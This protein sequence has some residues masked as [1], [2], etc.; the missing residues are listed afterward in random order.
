M[1]RR[2]G[3]AI[4]RWNPA[5]GGVWFVYVGGF[6][7][8]RVKRNPMTDLWSGF[9]P[10]SVP[11]IA[12]TRSRAIAVRRVVREWLDYPQTR[13][14]AG[15]DEPP[16]VW[17]AFLRL[18]RRVRGGA[19]PDPW[20]KALRQ[21]WALAGPPGRADAFGYDEDEEEDG[22]ESDGHAAAERKSR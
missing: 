8:G 9:S 2:T 20:R 16:E 4:L 14:E 21:A 13:R 3:A 22:P 7:V 1:K 12:P 19:W 17:R 11:F 15:G 5:Q 18:A 6:C 10:F